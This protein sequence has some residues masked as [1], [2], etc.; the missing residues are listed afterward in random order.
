MDTIKSTMTAKVAESAQ[1]MKIEVVEEKPVELI[2]E[3]S[4]AST[5]VEE[6]AETQTE[7]PILTSGSAD[8]KA[9]VKE[10]K[11]ATITPT[12]VLVVAPVIEETKKEVAAPVKITTAPVKIEP[13]VPKKEAVKA[14]EKKETPIM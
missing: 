7:T 12:P 1:P 8:K 5:N 14:P 3:K 13:V 4:T 11:I 9:E 6:S 2:V 10:V